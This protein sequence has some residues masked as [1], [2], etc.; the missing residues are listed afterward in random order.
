MTAAY[1]VATFPTLGTSATLVV[2]D[3]AFSAAALDIL[4][5]ELAAI[6]LACSRFRPDSELMAVNQAPPDV[7][8]PVSDMFLEATLAGIR[9][10]E[11]TGGL[12]DPTVGQALEMIGYDRDF[13]AISADGPALTF[14]A[15][16]VPG[17]KSVTVDP[18]ASTV[19]LRPGVRL[20]FGAT[21]KALCA[22]RAAKRIADET[23]TGTLVSLGGDIS[24]AG[25]PPDGGW[26]VK[27]GHDHRDPLDQP[28]PAVSIQSG[29]LATSSTTVRTWN[30]GG[31]TVNH[32]IDPRT[33]QSIHPWWTVVSVA[34]GSC[35]DAN[36]ASCASIVMGRSAP[37][38]LESMGLAGRL[39]SCSGE[40]TLV[41]G[42]P[43]DESQL[44]SVLPGGKPC[45]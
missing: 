26:S 43:S 16:S 21:A 14:T 12:V 25:P 35:L 7:P 42:W 36:I 18:A 5:A 9:A 30:R 28:G 41:G 38:W 3:E 22:D 11:I 6:D 29:G 1:R 27:I 44:Q 33:S 34:A 24:V 40:V 23:G 13:A 8:I 17:W 4:Q 20:D 15:R 32:I 45:W 37:E 10:A 39:E 19:Q 2:T 31:R